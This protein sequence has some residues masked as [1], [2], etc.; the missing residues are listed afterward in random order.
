MHRPKITRWRVGAGLI[1]LVGAMTIGLVI[2]IPSLPDV[3]RAAV[4]EEVNDRLP[5][6]TIHRI[7]PSWEGA[8]TVVTRCAGLE[9]DFQYVPGHGLPSNDA[10][11]HPSDAY[12]RQRLTELSDHWRHLIWRADHDRAERLSCADELARVGESPAERNLD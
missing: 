3:G 11:L 9:L 1:A 4:I 2:P 10:W 8:Y 6:W 7:Q 5:G 12:A